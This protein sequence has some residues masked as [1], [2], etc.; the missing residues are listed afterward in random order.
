MGSRAGRYCPHTTRTPYQPSSAWGS[1][2]SAES[3]KNSVVGYSSWVISAVLRLVSSDD[4]RYV[5]TTALP[6][7]HPLAR[8]R[9]V[10]SSPALGK[11]GVVR[12]LTVTGSAWAPAGG[13]H[14]ATPVATR[15]ATTEMRRRGSRGECRVRRIVSTPLRDRGRPGGGEDK[16]R[17]PGGS[18]PH[19]GPGRVGRVDRVLHAVRSTSRVRGRVVG[20]SRGALHVVATTSSASAT[21]DLAA[22]LAELAQ[23]GDLLLLAGDL[24]A[25]KTAFC[26]GFGRGLGVDEQI[27]SPTFTL[28]QSYTGRLDL[29]HLDVYRLE[30]LDE[31]VDLGLPS[32]STTGR[33]RSSSG[34]TRS[35]RCC[36]RTTSRSASGSATERRRPG[37]RAPAGRPALV[38]PH[39]APSRP[40]CRPWIE[41]RR[42]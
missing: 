22:A 13:D 39:A 37:A 28:V 19:R 5:S 24:G 10:T 9:T 12:V 16:G 6:G 42:A 41:R 3:W 30:Q 4:T 34:A 14:V 17:C 29:Y 15:N 35:R 31:V 8:T 2:T 38:R 36:R 7:G 1:F 26:Q 11:S 20:C 18:R 23:P 32:C 27:T 40:R 33:S 25:G 21:A